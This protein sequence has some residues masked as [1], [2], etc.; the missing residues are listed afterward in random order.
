MP[1]DFALWTL[2]SEKGLLLP[3]LES[4]RLLEDLQP[5]KLLQFFDLVLAIAPRLRQ[6]SGSMLS[7]GG[8]QTLRDLWRFALKV[9]R[10]GLERLSVE[11]MGNVERRLAQSMT[12]R[13]RWLWFEL[14]GDSNA[15]PLTPI[16]A[17][18]SDE[19]MQR[20]IA[21]MDEDLDIEVCG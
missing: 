17:P 16:V 12:R 7:E 14:V 20:L 19:E 13:L 10:R 15:A 4:F 5:A 8:T 3:H 9:E 1:P 11:V 18:V 6:L 2:K 21:Q